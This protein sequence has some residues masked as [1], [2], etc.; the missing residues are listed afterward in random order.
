MLAAVKLDSTP[1]F[2]RGYHYHGGKNVGV[3]AIIFLRIHLYLLLWVFCWSGII[4]LLLSMTQWMDGVP[5]EEELPQLLVKRRMVNPVTASSCVGNRLKMP[6]FQ[7]LEALYG[8]VSRRLAIA[9][10]NQMELVH[11]HLF[12][13]TTKD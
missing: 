3:M 1:T 8:D 12:M 6:P 2:V 5:S 10:L 13:P 11:S 4:L 9:A 7:L